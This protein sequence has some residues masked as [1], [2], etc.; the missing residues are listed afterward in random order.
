MNNQLNKKKS[1]YKPPF[2]SLLRKMGLM[3][4]SSMLVM[5]SILAAESYSPAP[6]TGDEAGGVLQTDGKRISGTVVDESGNPVIGANVVEKGTSNGTVSDV[7]G[8]FSLS[9]APNATL[10]VSFIGYLATNI[11]VGNRS[12]IT[13]RLREDSQALEEVVVVGYGTQKKLSLTGAVAAITNEQIVTTKSNNVQNALAGK[14]AGVKVSQGEPEPGLFNNE[15][16]IRGLGTPLIII[17]GVPREN[18]V[19]LDNNEIESISILKDAS[20]SIYGT[21]AANGVVLITTKKGQKA[22]KFQFDYNG[23]LGFERFINL[24]TPLDAIGF[25]TLRNEQVANRGEKTLPYSDADF[26]LYRNGTKKS[27]DWIFQFLNDTPLET[28]HSISATGGTDKIHFFANLGY[29]NQEGLWKGGL[30]SYDRYN[31]RSN[32][33]AEL[34]KGLTAELFLNLQYDLRNSQ[35]EGTWRLIDGAYGNPTINPVFI[36]DDPRYPGVAG[37]SRHLYLTTTKA[38]GY[39]WYAERNAQTNLALNWDVPWVK[40]LKLRGM[41]SYDWRGLEEKEF[42]TPFVQYYADKTTSA[43]NYNRYWR[44]FVGFTNTLLQLSANYSISIENHTLSAL[45]LYEENVR[46]ADNFEAKRD[47]ILTS[48]EQLFAGSNSNQEANQQRTKDI[49]GRNVSVLNHLVNKA[50]VGRLNYDYASKYLAEFSFRFDGSSRF[51][52]KRQ[53]GFFPAV[54]GG[55]RLSEEAFIKENGNLSKIINNLKLR[56]SYGLMGD[57]SD[58]AYQY[59]TGYD[60][61]NTSNQGGYS[62]GNNAGG[63]TYVYGITPR[64]VPNPDFSW[65][66]S[67]VIDIGLDVDL[68]SGLLGVEADVFRRNR[69][70]MK[71]TRDVVIPGEVGATIAQENL[72]SDQT[73]GIELTLSHR[74]KISEFRYNV[75]AFIAASRTKNLHIERAASRNSYSNWYDNSDNRYTNIAWGIDQIGNYQSFDEIFTGPIGGGSQANAYLLPGDWIFEDWNE[76]GIINGDDRHPIHTKGEVDGRMKPIA[77]YGVNLGA[78]YKNFD[79]SLTLQGSGST[80]RRND[81]TDYYEQALGSGNS[82]AGNGMDIFMDRWHRADEANPNKWQDWIPG[83]YPSTYATTHGGSN[84]NFLRED[85]RN[86]ST[87]WFYNAAYARVKSVE[88]GYTIPSYL[89]KKLSVER[90]RFYFNGFNVLTLTS[91]KFLDPEQPARYP[92]NRSYNIGVNISF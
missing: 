72:N 91:A 60:Y 59:L 50:A 4:I 85:W 83:Y 81:E 42:R 71:A 38:A 17:D 53:W 57:D 1:V 40:N 77:T 51:A 82:N 73:D 61:P 35:G 52:P 11:A 78:E 12:S 18:M 74:N 92:L 27:Q 21:R 69:D 65:I 29:Y 6:D 79:F 28:Q 66:S 36:D 25:M 9:V 49:D 2:N 67:K 7:N 87:F 63:Y 31:L 24:P 30:S 89:T 32:V 3:A 34:A 45:A 13:I 56:V 16:S 86:E 8:N 23:Y 10:Q 5:A 70:G 47:V 44:Q 37:N 14:I 90:A 48:V 75:S 68:W 55:W 46:K 15:F 19:R 22:S 84:R 58:V 43:N 62:F 41:Y 64:G 33:T 26:E 20:A 76:D 39:H 88:L 80:W 54:S